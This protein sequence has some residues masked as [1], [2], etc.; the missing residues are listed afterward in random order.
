MKIVIPKKIKKTN[1]YNQE[2]YHYELVK[3]QKH[4]VIYRCLENGYIETFSKNEF[5]KNE[6]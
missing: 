4:I 3:V 2:C 5:V 1:N 6:E